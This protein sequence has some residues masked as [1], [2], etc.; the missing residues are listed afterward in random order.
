MLA[1][2]EAATK[3]LEVG[4]VIVGVNETEV[5]GLPKKGVSELLPNCRRPFTLFVAAKPP[6]E[7][8]LLSYTFGYVSIA[9]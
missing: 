3:G 9:S 2:S 1:G 6:P 4:S 8:S 5:L 7:P